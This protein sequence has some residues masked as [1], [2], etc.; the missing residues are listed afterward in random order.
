MSIVCN[1]KKASDLVVGGR[2]MREAWINGEKIWPETF[3]KLKGVAQKLSNGIIQLTPTTMHVAGSAWYVLPLSIFDL[4]IEFDYRIGGGT[5]ADGFVILF[6][7]E[8]KS[9]GTSG[10]SEDT[11]LGTNI[12]ENTYGIEFDTFRNAYDPLRNHIA[13]IKGSIKNH[14]VY[15]TINKLNDDTFH[16]AVATWKNESLTLTVDGIQMIQANNVTFNMPFYFGFS[17]STGTYTDEHQIRN[18][19]VNGKNIR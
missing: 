16:H 7:N 10:G 3:W 18:I 15:T 17:A 13:L 1:Q 5:G 2:H 4:T 14:L 9:I 6:A 19:N 11:A 8:I 12:D